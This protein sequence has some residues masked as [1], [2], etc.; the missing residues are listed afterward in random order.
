MTAQQRA[1]VDDLGNIAVHGRSGLVLVV[2]IE[3][4]TAG[5]YEDISARD[6]FFEIAGKLRLALS[7]GADNYSRQVI[8]TRA[9]VATLAISRPYAFAIHDETPATPSTPWAGTITTFGFKTAPAGVADVDGEATNWSGATVIIQ[10]GGGTPVA[11]IEYSGATGPAAWGTPAAWVT[12]TAYTATAPRSVVT[13]AGSSYVC[14][15]SH[16]AG[17]FGTD[18]AAAKWLLIASGGSAGNWGSIGGTLTDQT[19]LQ[20]AL[21]AKQASDAD[22]TAIAALTSAADKVPYATGAGAWA[23]AD[24]TAAGRALLDDA[25]A[26]AQRTTLGL[27]IGTNVQAYSATLAAVAGGTYTGAS[28]I[29][30]LGTVTTGVWNGTAIAATSGGTGQTNYAVGDVLF[31]STTSALSRLAAGTSGHVL[32]S[33]GAGV[34]PSYQ[35]VPAT[36]TGG[37]LTSALGVVLGSASAPGIYLS[38]DTNTGI[39]SSGADVLGI[40]TGG[41]ARMEVNATGLVNIGQTA[42][43]AQLGVQSGSSSRTA[44][45]VRMAA[46]QSVDAL[47]VQTSGGGVRFQVSPVGNLAAMGSATAA[48]VGLNLGTGGERLDSTGNPYLIQGQII[49]SLSGNVRGIYVT[50]ES[51][52]AGAIS[53]IIGFAATVSANNAANAVGTGQSFFAQTPTLMAGAAI[54]T[55][56]GVRINAQ[57]VTGVTTGYSIFATGTDDL[58]HFAH[59]VLIGNT[60]LPASMV[61]VGIVLGNI[62]TV[63]SGNPSSGGTLYSEAGALKWRGS[64]GTVTTIANA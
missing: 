31:A 8:L 42:L 41:V 32:T 47:Q 63:P 10:P 23:L 40:A 24:F 57:K 28:S 56:T 22:L 35:S 6:L 17:T 44:M 3:T 1:V 58:A 53:S 27:V 29:T 11:V 64:S 30:T 14:L 62:G 49:N 13:N 34:A 38:G 16:T 43:T 2:K 12:G 20:T 55:M 50:A 9:Q 45:I 60:A 18:L 51:R 46:S 36:F 4:T 37:L 59:P 15:V 61:G 21:N 19:D 54:T 39:W 52:F 25:D 7:A 33:N 5:T 26:A 48:D